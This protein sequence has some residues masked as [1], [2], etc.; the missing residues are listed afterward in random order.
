MKTEKKKRRRRIGGAAVKEQRCGHE[1]AILARLNERRAAVAVHANALEQ[2]LGRL[3]PSRRWR[4]CRH[5][6]GCD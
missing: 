3:P 4:G 1:V 5:G 2:L 6:C